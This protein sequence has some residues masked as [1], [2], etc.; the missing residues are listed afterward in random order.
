VKALNENGFNDLHV[1]KTFLFFLSQMTFVDFIK[2]LL[3]V[4]SVKRFLLIL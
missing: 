1:K 3:K 4:L 2:N